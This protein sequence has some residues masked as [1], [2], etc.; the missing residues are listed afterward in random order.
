MA[1]HYYE[2]ENGP[3]DNDKQLEVKCLDQLHWH[4]NFFTQRQKRL[5]IARE[6]VC[7]L[8]LHHQSILIWHLEFQVGPAM[9]AGEVLNKDS[10][11]SPA[12][13]I[14]PITA[15]DSATEGDFEQADMD[16]LDSELKPNYPHVTWLL[17]IEWSS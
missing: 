6:S 9:L 3:I 14:L 11:P 10:H 2:T 17:D 7:K 8:V 5:G 15:A 4:W 16:A 13:G 1:K 12:S